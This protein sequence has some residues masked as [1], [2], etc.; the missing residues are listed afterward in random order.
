MASEISGESLGGCAL[1]IWHA[2]VTTPM[3][4]TLVF[5]I[6]QANEMPSWAWALYFCYVPASI[7]GVIISGVVQSLKKG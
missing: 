7:I 6:M 1:V 2:F 5:A 4:L 3:W